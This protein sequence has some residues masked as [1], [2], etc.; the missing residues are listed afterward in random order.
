MKTKLTVVTL[1]ALFVGV[2]FPIIQP[3]YTKSVQIQKSA[4]KFALLVGINDYTDKDI[5]DLSGTEND[6][7]L[8][9]D[10]LTEV[11]NFN[12]QSDIRKLV[13][14]NSKAGEKPT[15][16]I[17]LNS[18][19]KHLIENAKKYFTDNKLTTPD[20][21]ATIVFYY[22]GHGSHLT[23]DNN[24]ETDGEDETIV[25]MDSDMSGTKDIRDDDFDK[26]FQELKKY[27]SNITFIFDSCH[28]GTITR[29]V[30]KR[31]LERP[32]AVARKRGD[33]TDVTLNESMDSSG[34]S[35]VTISGS[36]PNQLSYEDLLP[37]PTTKKDQQNGFMTYYLVQ[38][39]RENPDTT[40]RD[41][42]KKVQ[43][44]VQKR[45]S[46]QTPQ[47]EGDIDRVM[48]GSTE[49][50][51]RTGILINNVRTEEVERDGKKVKDSLLTIEA[52]KIVGAYPGGAVAIYK[53]IGDAEMLGVGEIVEATDFTSTVKVYEKEIP[54][55]AKVVL[56]TPFFGSNK[57]IVV[58]DLTPKKDMPEKDDVGLQMIRR[59]TQN[60]E[61]N[62]Y[63][64]AKPLTNPLKEKQR[65][66]DVA[67]VRSTYGEFKRGNLQSPPPKDSKAVIPKDDDEIY[68]LANSKGDP[69][70]NF[71]VKADEKADAEIEK[72]LEKFVRVENLKTLGNG[73][74]EMDK[75]LEM[76]IVK[77]KSLKQPKPESLSD[78]VED[79][80]LQNAS[81]N[82]GDYYSFEI[83]NKTDQPVFIYVYSIGTDGSIKL[84]YGPKADGDK[85]QS[86][87]PLKVHKAGI[88][89]RIAPPF[90][91]ETFKL[92]AASQRFNG[93]LL[94][95]PAIARTKSRGGSALETLLAQASTNTRNSDLITFEFSGWAATSLDV[96]IK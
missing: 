9:G 60:L 76:K 27:T 83:I 26:R 19:D 32:S 70:Y 15:K 5:P 16:A 11:Y 35:Y 79:G 43:M 82:V 55:T 71:W 87:V 8:I 81:L 59:L 20:K 33:G 47:V 78:I 52:G 65:D 80:Y 94:E 50:R 84:V 17:I 56:T 58:L 51:A 7:G 10:M 22:S 49:T 63:V 75:G 74:S 67:V 64:A 37:H 24:D 36:L 68:Y 92:I 85:L 41:A 46:A 91:V 62:D 44:A 31:S 73:A 61:K 12:S 34:E 69:L 1:Y 29:G 86:N 30:G 48:F 3:I 39:L 96:E 42:M 77:L 40:Y 45:T 18:F 93:N 90:G 38:T 54:E 28:S 14:S 72:A 21:G 89:A 2:V 13:T 88:I 57:R 4:P 25:P 23:D 95:S 66:W 53:K 6:V